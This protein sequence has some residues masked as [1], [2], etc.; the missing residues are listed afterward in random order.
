MTNYIYWLR[1]MAEREEMSIRPCPKALRR[2][3]DEWEKDKATL[4]AIGELTTY[5]ATEIIGNSLVVRELDV[6]AI[7]NRSNENE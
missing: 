7:L 2:A 4:K 6:E 3:A 1:D 5:R